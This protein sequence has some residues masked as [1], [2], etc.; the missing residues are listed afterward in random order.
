LGKVVVDDGTPL[1]IQ[2]SAIA[3]GIS[4]P[5]ALVR[6]QMRT[7]P[8]FAGAFSPK[9]DGFLVIPLVPGTYYPEITLLPLGYTVKSLT[10]GTIDVLRSF[11]VTELPASEIRLTLTRQ[12]ASDPSTGV[13]VSGR[14]IG[15]ASDTSGRKH[16]I[17]LQKALRAPSS[18]PQPAGFREYVGES[19]L[20]ADGTFEFRGVFPDTWELRLSSIDGLTATQ[21]IVVG[22]QALSGIELRAGAGRR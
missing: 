6:L 7:G 14:V 16:W 17:T 1:P 4:D 12:Q 13:V 15:L 21:T 20:P 22:T 10:Y 2:S 11:E 19:A 3:L 5:P 9:K 18:A 8:R